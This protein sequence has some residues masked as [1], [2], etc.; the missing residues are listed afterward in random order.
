[1][2]IL[3]NEL[4]LEHY[5]TFIDEQRDAGEIEVLRNGKKTKAKNLKSTDIIAKPQYKQLQIIDINKYR[6]SIKENI[7]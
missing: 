4:F 5:I 6:N 2:L 1:M 3:P 7:K